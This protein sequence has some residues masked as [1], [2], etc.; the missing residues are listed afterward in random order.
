MIQN[1]FLEKI[2]DLHGTG[3]LMFRNR[4]ANLGGFPDR[5]AL[6]CPL[7]KEEGSDTDPKIEWLVDLLSL[8]ENEKVLIICR[9]IEDT[10]QLNE[11]LLEKIRIKTTLFHEGLELI[12]RDRSAAY[13]AEEDGARVLISSEIGSE[14]RNFQF[15]SKL[16]PF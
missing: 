2:L 11:A 12:K 5:E 14:G 16:G 13:F 1:Y 8:L 7:K 3:R 6:L 4:R 15:A 9:T 10:E